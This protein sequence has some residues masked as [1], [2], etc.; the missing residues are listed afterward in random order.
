MARWV[1]YGTMPTSILF[2]TIEQSYLEKGILIADSAGSEELSKVQSRI[3]A[4]RHELERRCS[5]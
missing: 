2:D 4:A 3:D 1:N 5:W